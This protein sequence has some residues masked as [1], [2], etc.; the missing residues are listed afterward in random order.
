MLKIVDDT[1]AAVC[2]CVKI[3]THMADGK[4]VPNKV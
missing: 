1:T 2:E 4:I 3:Q